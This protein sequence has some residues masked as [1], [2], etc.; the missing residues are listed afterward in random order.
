MCGIF[1]IISDCEINRNHLRKLALHAR[2]RGRDSSGL[3]YLNKVGY[4]VKR[5]DYDIAK[6]LKKHSN[7]HFGV[8]MGHSRLI[9]NGLSDNQPVV[10]D[11]ISLIHNGIIVNEEELWSSIDI[12]R[13]YHIDSEIIIGVALE[14]LNNGGE[15]RDIPKN[16]IEKCHGTISCAITIPGKGKA[17]LFSNNGSLYF[18][19]LD[20]AT[21]FASE[22][23]PLVELGCTNIDQ[24]WQEGKIIDIPISE[25]ID[26][27][28]DNVRKEDLIPVFKNIPLEEAMLIYCEPEIKRCTRCILPETMP[29]IKFDSKGV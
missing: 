16:V 15:I 17:I 20:E 28:D 6:L 21:Y 9:T 8:I 7:E 14:H 24:I 12:E 4:K 27:I 13:K 26:I 25:K 10:R 11:G 5:A 29:Y 1:G 22:K 19:E 3:L 23:H 18:G 2:Q